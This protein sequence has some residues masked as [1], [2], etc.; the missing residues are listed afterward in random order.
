[1]NKSTQAQS[2]QASTRSNAF[3]MNT[4][5]INGDDDKLEEENKSI[6]SSVIKLGRLQH[7]QIKRVLP[8]DQISGGGLMACLDEGTTSG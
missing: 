7:R 6:S 4:L 3:S 5:S 1:M 2:S 8:N